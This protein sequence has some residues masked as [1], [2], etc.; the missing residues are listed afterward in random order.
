MHVYS[1]FAE[2]WTT[3]E[4]MNEEEREVWTEK[5]LQWMCDTKTGSDIRFACGQALTG[6][7][8]ASESHCLLTTNTTFTY[9]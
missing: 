1:C 4:N 6:T 5:I 8:L 7:C 9:S 3:A 2:L